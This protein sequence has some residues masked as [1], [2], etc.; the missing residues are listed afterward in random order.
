MA[1]RL[2]IALGG[3]AL[4]ETESHRS[5]VSEQ[6]GAARQAFAAIADVMARSEHVLV[7]HGNGPQVGSLLMRSDISVDVQHLPPLPLDTCV[8]DT[9]GGLGYTLARELRNALEGIGVTCDVAP[10]V[11]SVLVEDLDGPPTKPIGQSYPAER[12]AELEARGWTVAETPEGRVRRVVRSPAPERVLEL[13]AIRRLYESGTIV[14]AGG[15]GGVPVR[16]GDDGE[17][18]GVEAVIDKDLVACLLARELGAETLLILT[19]VERVAVHYGTPQ[20]RALDRVSA[21]ELRALQREGHFPPGSMGPKVEAALRFVEQG[22]GEAIVS[23]LAAASLALAGE[24]GTRVVA[25]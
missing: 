24:T 1:R 21:S 12:R 2:V 23:S 14:I 7:V 4:S 8:A 25:G 20:E 11:T 19:N 13:R 16:L 18:H 9:A 17:L 5:S 3:N 10:I 15:G 6:A 22:G